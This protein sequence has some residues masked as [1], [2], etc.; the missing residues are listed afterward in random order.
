[1]TFQELAEALHKECRNLE[2]G[3]SMSFK[4]TP[5]LEPIIGYPVLRF[6]LRQIQKD[7]NI[8]F[9]QDGV[10]IIT[11]LSPTESLKLPKPFWTEEV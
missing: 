7:L 9:G 11:R 3:R 6:K 10:V 8:I 1:M 2:R 4:L 5:P